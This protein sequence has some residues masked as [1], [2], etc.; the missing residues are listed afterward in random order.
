MDTESFINRI[1]GIAAPEITWWQ[2]VLRALVVY[3][4][5]IVLVRAGNKRFMAK[6]TAFDLVL[7]ILL[8]SVASRTITGNS[9][10]ISSL[11]VLVSLVALHWIF[12]ALAFHFDYL[13]G[14]LK[15]KPRLLIEDGKV[16][17]PTM[18]HSHITEKE[19]LEAL[20]MQFQSTDIGKVKEAWLERNGQ[21]SFVFW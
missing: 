4:V 19:L 5:V 21:I 7:A 9:P 16:Q 11:T 14:W 13:G 15:G 1:F 18:R 2:M 17:W 8:G 3:V 10:L 12:A 20:R 6:G